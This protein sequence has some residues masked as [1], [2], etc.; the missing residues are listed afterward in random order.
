MSVRNDYSI[1]SC[2]STQILQRNRQSMTIYFSSYITE[3]A[4]I[5]GNDCSISQ[6]SIL[7]S[8]IQQ[9]SGKKKTTERLSFSFLVQLNWENML[10][11]WGSFKD[12]I[13][14]MII[15]RRF[16]VNINY[17]T[18]QSLVGNK[19]EKELSR[20]QDWTCMSTNHLKNQAKTSPL[21]LYKKRTTMTYYRQCKY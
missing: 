10:V 20:K 5:Q 14:A 7:I 19:H 9:Q 11:I 16:Q 8:L 18:L 12:N 4:D 2:C 1:I 6:K 17:F 21:E 13:S 15:I 3:P